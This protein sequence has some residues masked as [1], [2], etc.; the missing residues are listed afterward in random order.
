MIRRI[1][2]IGLA[3]AVLPAA[4]AMADVTGGE[5][6]IIEEETAVIMESAVSAPPPAWVEPYPER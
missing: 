2:I 5:T 4:I 1:T 3:F 6:V